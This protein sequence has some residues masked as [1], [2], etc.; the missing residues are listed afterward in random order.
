MLVSAV[1]VGAVVHG[2][3]A[4]MRLG[5]SRCSAGFVVDERS[6]KARPCDCA[7]VYYAHKRADR[8]ARAVPRRFRNMS[9][10]RFPLNFL[11]AGVRSELSA[12]VDA[13]DENISE[14]RGL[15]LTG[16]PGSGKSAAAAMIV[17]EVNR[18]P[19]LAGAA[20]EHA[21]VLLDRI[22]RTFS[23]DVEGTQSEIHRQLMAVPL[24]VL[25]DISAVRD[26]VWS[27]EQLYMILNNRYGDQR[28]TIVTSTTTRLEQGVLM[29]L[30]ALCGPPVAF[31]PLMALDAPEQTV[32]ATVAPAPQGAEGE[33]RREEDR[34]PN[35]GQRPASPSPD[36][37]AE[38]QSELR[39]GHLH[40]RSTVATS[41]A[42]T[43][44]LQYGSDRE[45][46]A[47]NGNGPSPMGPRVPVP[48][49]TAMP[50]VRVLLP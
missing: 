32:A 16:P 19:K 42:P 23:D 6:R 44:D 40:E 10:D 50:A 31:P 21:P 25:D 47:A 24:L 22:R 1:G 15:W 48:A 17:N 30:R 39:Y 37:H 43:S 14:G 7:R 38:P 3:A 34:Q 26:T 12:Y 18:R 8:V 49:A 27:A 13:L 9:L 11:A 20:F 29:R 4:R 45:S 36:R 35:S 2:K 33:Q 5:C 46:S 28:A 41:V